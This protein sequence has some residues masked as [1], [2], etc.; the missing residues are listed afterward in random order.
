MGSL[1][2]IG[3]FQFE[4]LVR[5]RIPFV[6]LNLGADLKGLFPSFL[7]TQMESQM[8]AT[9]PENALQDLSGKHPAKDTAII[10]ICEN[11]ERSLSLAEKLVSQ[12]YHNVY[13]LGGG[14]R[15]LRPL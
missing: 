12:G 6:L 2:E 13:C 1:L 4:N 15:A 3:A 11:G 9:T 10:V 5:N 7:Q 8:T 14:R